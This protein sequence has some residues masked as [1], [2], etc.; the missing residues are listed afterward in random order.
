[1]LIILITSRTIFLWKNGPTHPQRALKLTKI[2]PNLWPVDRFI[3]IKS[4]TPSWCH[5][6]NQDSMQ[7][8]VSSTKPK[9]FMKLLDFFEGTAKHPHSLMHRWRL[10]LWHDDSVGWLSRVSALINE[11]VFD[12]DWWGGA[13]SV[14]WTR[15][16]NDDYQPSIDCTATDTLAS[17][18]RLIGLEPGK[19]RG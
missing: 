13:G 7:W 5:R 4:L 1:M 10:R 15:K 6:S 9:H 2:G 8:L 11:R 18:Q 14:W 12:W 16:W 3:R 19:S 17:S